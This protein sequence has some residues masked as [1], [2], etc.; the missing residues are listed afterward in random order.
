MSVPY[1]WAIEMKLASVWTDVTRDVIKRDKSVN[2][3][4][5]INGQLPTNVLPDIGTLS[6]WMDN[7]EANSGGKLGYYSLDHADCRAG[8]A[9]D[10]ETRIKFV[11]DGVTKYFLHSWI[12]QAEPTAGQ[13]RER[14]AYVHASNYIQKLVTNRTK[15][16]PVQQNKR[17][18]QLFD[19]II[20]NCPIAPLNTSYDVDP[21]SSSLALHLQRDEETALSNALQKVLQSTGARAYILGDA[22][23]G[24]TLAYANR[25][26][27]SLTPLS[28]TF[29]NSMSN[30]KVVRKS[31]KTYDHVKATL[32]PCEIDTSE[33]VLASLQGEVAIRPGED[34]DVEMRLRDPAG[35][36]R[37]SGIDFIDPLVEDTD[38]KI[39]AY[40]GSSGNDMNAAVTVTLTPGGNTSKVRI[41]NNSGTIAFCNFLKLRCKGIYPYDSID[42][43]FG[44]GTE[45]EFALSLPYMSSVATARAIG[46]A[47]LAYVTQDLPEVSGLEYYPDASDAFMD[48]FMTLDF[49]SRIGVIEEATGLNAEFIINGFDSV[50]INNGLLK[51]TYALAH[52]G[53]DNEVFILDDPVKGILD[54]TVYRL[55][56]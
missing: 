23:D 39:T 13:F 5:I 41:H 43:T 2:M 36:T 31:Q 42:F 56:A 30:V 25:Y 53:V 17:F 40:S 35:N 4:S 10:T 45:R 27:R 3:R 6:Y 11:Y 48:N 7:S 20:D 33:I 21:S 22:T 34:F 18:D 55:A 12:D 9:E 24:E 38:Y 26:N 8:F 14:H 49:G 16:I 54:N 28:A 52:P 46:Q 44:S 32:T 29:N 50:E 51:C 47:T 37:I 15:R 1:T 19:T